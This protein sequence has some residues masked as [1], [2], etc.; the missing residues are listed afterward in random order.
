MSKSSEVSIAGLSGPSGSGHDPRN[1]GK[2]VVDDEFYSPSMVKSL[3]AERDAALAQNA[4]LVA[5]VEFWKDTAEDC[6]TMGT[7]VEA[8]HRFE[9][10]LKKSPPQHLQD[11][12]ADAVSDF[13]EFMHKSRD[14]QLCEK[15]LNA[16]TQY[17]E[18]VKAGE[19]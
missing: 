19:V 14:C 7:K 12:Q 18:R 8:C 10:A 1:C 4:E 11:I 2:V 9:A 16:A 6:A 15:S 17:A 3:I 13:I 5:Q